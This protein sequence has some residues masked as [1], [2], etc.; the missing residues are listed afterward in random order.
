[1]A[2]VDNGPSTIANKQ[3]SK[4]FA[5]VDEDDKWTEIIEKEDK[6]TSPQPEPTA[7]ATKPPAQNPFSVSTFGPAVGPP[8]HDPFGRPLHTPQSALEAQLVLIGEVELG[9]LNA[10]AILERALIKEVDKS[11]S[12]PYQAVWLIH[13]P[14]RQN[15]PG[16]RST[17]WSSERFS[18]SQALRDMGYLIGLQRAVNLLREALGNPNRKDYSYTVKVVEQTPPQPPPLPHTIVSAMPP[19][20]VTQ[21]KELRGVAKDI[22]KDTVREYKDEIITPA[23]EEIQKE[24]IKLCR[25]VCRDALQ[26]KG[27]REV[28]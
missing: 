8:T 26:N 3:Q 11:P 7:S 15:T 28:E 16:T 10:V 25:D 12:E 1:M 23:M 19:A 13:P 18:S 2:P 27:A 22:V 17:I 20:G 9:L 6:D 21:D 4:S 5:A 24:M 14:L